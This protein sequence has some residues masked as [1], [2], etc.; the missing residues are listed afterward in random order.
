MSST[1]FKSN[2]GYIKHKILHLRQLY[3]QPVCNT[4]V[5]IRTV[6]RILRELAFALTGYLQRTFRAFRRDARTTSPSLFNIMHELGAPEELTALVH[7]N[8]ENDKDQSE[9]KTKDQGAQCV[10]WEKELSDDEPDEATLQFDSHILQCTHLLKQIEVPTVLFDPNDSASDQEL[11]THKSSKKKRKGRKHKSA[12]TDSLPQET[13]DT[14]SDANVMKEMSERYGFDVSALCPSVKVAQ[15]PT[16]K[17]SISTTT[18]SVDVSRLVALYDKNEL[19]ICITPYHELKE[20]YR[21]LL[22]RD[23]SKRYPDIH[24]LLL[25]DLEM[26]RDEPQHFNQPVNSYF[27]T[28]ACAQSAPYKT[29]RKGKK[30]R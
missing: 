16:D 24:E 13:E 22:K 3:I 21:F 23:P 25:V 8:S 7:F 26:M 12:K 30:R 10:V 4:T 29:K 5:W 27:D 6:D 9:D 1:A 19:N 15:Q 11:P 17:L 18:H 28:V 20:L 2:P 14:Y